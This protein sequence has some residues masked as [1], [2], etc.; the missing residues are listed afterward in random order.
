M[1]LNHHAAPHHATHIADELWLRAPLRT[2]SAPA[3]EED[4]LRCSFFI[5]SFFIFVRCTFAEK[6]KENRRVTVLA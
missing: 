5:I 1:R 4:A 3:P 2:E 6:V